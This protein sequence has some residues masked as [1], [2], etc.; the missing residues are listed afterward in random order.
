M[1]KP[2][3]ICGA[4][5]AA[6]RCPAHR[7]IRRHRPSPHAPGYGQ[8]W[9][10]TAREVYGELCAY[11]AAPADTADH[12]VPKS[13]GGTDDKDNVVPACRACNSKKRDQ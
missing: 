7:L 6:S 10:R 2:C 13:R 11:G 4:L 9:Q 8:A 1:N 5:T 3:L 12:V